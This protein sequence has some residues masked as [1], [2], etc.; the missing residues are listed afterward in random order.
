LL[1][2]GALF[3]VCG[4]PLGGGAAGAEVAV[5]ELGLT[6]GGAAAGGVVVE[7]APAGD[8]VRTENVA[9]ISSR[10]RPARSEVLK[11]RSLRRASGE[12]RRLPRPA[13][14]ADGGDLR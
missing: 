11:A 5:S 12:W 3:G 1:A 6:G 14:R 7:Q 10:H 2:G 8:K 9:M 13:G 4:A